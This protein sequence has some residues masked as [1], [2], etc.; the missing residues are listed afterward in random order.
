M[1]AKVTGKQMITV[2][3]H[4]VILRHLFGVNLAAAVCQCDHPLP[5]FGPCV[6]G[7][8]S[9]LIDDSQAYSVIV[10]TYVTT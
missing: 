4:A 7:H 6:N 10:D 3:Q 8:H 1:E 5:S 9:R 2:S